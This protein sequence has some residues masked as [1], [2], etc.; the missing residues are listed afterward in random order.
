[1]TA[2]LPEPQEAIAAI[3][4]TTLEELERSTQ[5]DRA[6][7]RLEL[8]SQS[9]KYKPYLRVV[10]EYQRY[11]RENYP[12]IPTFPILPPLAYVF[13]KYTAGRERRRCGQGDNTGESI[14]GSLVGHQTV[15]QV[16]WH[17]NSIFCSPS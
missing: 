15:K 14:P 17:I 16:R 2:R 3:P 8:D 11:I 6:Q 1:M 13:V 5:D 9:R 4:A 12:W 10:R 7:L